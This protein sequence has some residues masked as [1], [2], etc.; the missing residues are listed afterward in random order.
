MLMSAVSPSQTY[1]VSETSESHLYA[2]Y[3][4]SKAGIFPLMATKTYI[5]YITYT[6]IIYICCV[7]KYIYTQKCIR[8]VLLSS[9]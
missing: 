4:E 1:G 6:Y 3:V 8:F 5:D 9:L 7:M 2:V